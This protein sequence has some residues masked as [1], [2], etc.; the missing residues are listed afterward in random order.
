[1]LSRAVPAPRHLFVAACCIALLSATGAEN[2]LQ[3]R[4]WANTD[5]AF[6]EFAATVAGSHERNL[7]AR[8]GAQLHDGNG[9]S[10]IAALADGEA[11]VRGGDCRV[12]IDGQPSVITCYLGNAGL[13]GRFLHLQ[14]RCPR[15]SGL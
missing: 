5:E 6:A 14:H 2:L 15:Q 11:G 12:A 4:K 9:V 3:S 8:R 7:L 10:D 1:M 13:P